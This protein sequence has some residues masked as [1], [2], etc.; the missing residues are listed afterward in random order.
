MA[1]SPRSSGAWTKSGPI[2][3]PAL[4]GADGRPGRV[5]RRRGDAGVS[6]P[7]VRRA[8]RRGAWGARPPDRSRPGPGGGAH[9]LGGVQRPDAL[10]KRS[11]LVDVAGALPGVV[12]PRVPDVPG[13][14]GDRRER[15]HGAGAG[16]V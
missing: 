12:G 14:H 8:V 5:L 1:T 3:E 15:A 2:C 6:A 7:V 9:V 13:R 11:E 4:Q 10:R 16:P